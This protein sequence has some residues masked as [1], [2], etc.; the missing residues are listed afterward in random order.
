[1]SLLWPDTLFM[2]PLNKPVTRKTATTLDGSYGP[3]RGKAIV[4]RLIP[5][6]GKA[7]PD[8]LELRPEKTRRPE[9]IAVADVYRYA[10]RSRINFE[11]LEKARKRKAAKQQQRE[12]RRLD[13]KER[14]LRKEWSTV[15]LSEALSAADAHSD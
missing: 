6:D 12:A 14:R 5:G 3:D 11:L 7:I 9:R 2:T 15:P 8:L 13:A 10:M 1:M 4:V